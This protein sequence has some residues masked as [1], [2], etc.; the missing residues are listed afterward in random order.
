[1]ALHSGLK[2]PPYPAPFMSP[3]T[4]E[5]AFICKGGLCRCNLVRPGILLYWTG[6]AHAPRLCRKEG[7]VVGAGGAGSE[8]R[9]GAAEAEMR[10]WPRARECRR[11]PEPRA[12]TRQDRSSGALQEGPALPLPSF[13]AL[14]SGASR[15]CGPL[16]HQ[17]EP[18]GKT[19]N[20]L[21]ALRPHGSLSLKQPS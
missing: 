1:M 19:P 4:L 10:L 8:E 20:L 12:S 17:W 16:L 5:Y 6:M 14:A 2:N 11:L 21:V 3:G 13:R 9:P 15:A 7:M 18:S